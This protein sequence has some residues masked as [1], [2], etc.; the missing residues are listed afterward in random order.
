MLGR[1]PKREIPTQV[2]SCEYCKISRKSYFDKYLQTA[3]F[4]YESSL[5]IK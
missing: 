1:A 5:Q 2:L 4:K 3:A